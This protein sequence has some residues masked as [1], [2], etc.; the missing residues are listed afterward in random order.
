MQWVEMES[1]G[2]TTP[3]C[4]PLIYLYVYKTNNMYIHVTFNIC[5]DLFWGVKLT[6]KVFYSVK[7]EANTMDQ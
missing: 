6:F 4:E 5:V 2:R 7:K 1:A 3:K